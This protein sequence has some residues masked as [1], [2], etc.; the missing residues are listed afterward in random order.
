MT[1]LELKD[2]K[3]EEPKMKMKRKKKNRIDGD[4]EKKKGEKNVENK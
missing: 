1:K 4:I 2:N 3:A